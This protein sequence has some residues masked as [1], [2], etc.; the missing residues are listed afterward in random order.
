MADD[1]PVQSFDLRRKQPQCQNCPFSERD[2]DDGKLYCHETSPKAQAVFYFKPPEAKPPVIA[3]VGTRPMP[4]P[5]LVVH[6]IVTFWPE[7]QPDWLCWQHPEKQEE[8]RRHG[9]ASLPSTHTRQP[10]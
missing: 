5:E 7:V 4:T 6:G 8:R 9:F 2:I 10:A 3:G 1:V